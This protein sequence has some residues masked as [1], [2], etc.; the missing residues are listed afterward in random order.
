MLVNRSY[1]HEDVAYLNVI[2]KKDSNINMMKAMVRS[3][4]S[5][6]VKTFLKNSRPRPWWQGSE[7][8]IENSS[9]V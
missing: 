2:H 9:L 4:H 6:V 5:L 8:E 1:A 3:L 7:I